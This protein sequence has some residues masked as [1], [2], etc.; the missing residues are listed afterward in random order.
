MKELPK[1]YNPKEN[2][3][4]IYQQWEK[5]GF[6]NPDK[7]KVKKTAKNYS[8]V[9]PPPNITGELH[10][11]HALNNTLQDI[12]IRWKRMQGYKTLWIVG[13]DHAG[14]ATQNVVEKQL[15]KEGLTRHDIGEKELIKRIWDWQEKYGD[16]IL[17][18]LKKIGC[19][20]DWSRTVFTMDSNYQKAVKQTFLHY[21]KKGWIY[22]GERV[23][24]WCPRCQTSLSDLE[25]EYK[26]EKSY[27]WY[28]KYPMAKDKNQFIC[29]ATTRP[30]TMLGDTA[31]AVHPDDKKYKKLIGQKVILPLVNREIP[32]ITDKMID[33]EFGTG[34][35]KVTPAHSPIDA[36]IAE[37]NKL[38]FIQVIGQDGKITKAA[39]RNFEGLTVLEARKKVIDEL[40]KQGLLEKTE[41]YIHQ[42]P[43][44][45]RCNS[46]IEPLISKQWFV[47]MDELAK[48]A[49]DVVK[50]GKI[51]FHPKRAEKI[52]FNWMNNIK[53]WCISRQIWWGHKIP[54][55]G[56]TDVLDTWF[57]SA[58]WPFATLG[59]PEQTK[60][61]KEF[62]P[63]DVLSTA[64]DITNLWVARMIFSGLEFMKDIPFSDVFIHPTILNKQGKR[65]S[66]SLGT[67]I[68]P[69]K[70]VD[71]FG[72]DAMRFGL[73]YQVLHNQ[74]IHFSE[75]NMLMGKKFAN[76]IW[77]A[78]RFV[79][80]QIG[81]LKLQIKSF[82]SQTKFTK[83]DKIILKKLSEIIQKV[84]SDL[85]NFHFG[86]AAHSLYDFFWHD[87]CDK[88]IETAKK[89]D[90]DQ[91][92]QILAYI[93]LNSLKL[94]HPFMP[95]VTETIYQ[96]LPFKQKKFLMV[97]NWPRN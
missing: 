52:Y 23:I 12:L 16:L 93:L 91:T 10:M 69:L 97:E 5:S 83:A 41:D 39:G 95:F 8:I 86:Q 25:L 63:T 54:I 75:E 50:D 4:K 71:E 19:S 32:I 90:D 65:M 88:Y 13:T 6:F 56:E 45:Y 28:L 3:E 9:I 43:I 48:K 2:E 96:Q 35:V 14:I 7:L 37:R 11:G 47:K 46:I 22:K 89:Q 82:K 31:V 72:A 1:A 60:D 84:D 36:E 53:D 66:K 70:M 76:K 18:Q 30:E 77:N 79:L 68:D 40:E 29:V 92:K 67:G 15:K 17:D 78:S 85:E 20:C 59:W 33:P 38:K 81:D 26:E 49:I 34:A 64:R 57:S 51:K 27:L 24:N 21:Y 94:L 73:T 55:K 80:W 74:D 44:C 61:L 42:V 87:F 62:Y 58:L